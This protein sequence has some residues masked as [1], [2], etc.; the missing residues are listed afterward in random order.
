MDS[1]FPSM[2]SPFSA[3]SP[4]ADALRTLILFV[5][6]LV[7]VIALLVMSLVA[8]A[9]IRYRDRGTAVEPAQTGGNRKVEIAYT[10]IPLAIM[11]GLFALTV[12]TMHRAEPKETTAPPDLVI[13]AHQWWWELRYPGTDVVS[14][15][16]IH[17]PVGRKMVVELRSAD[18]IH[19][20]WV[21]QLAPKM[22]AVPGKPNRLIMEADRP[23]VYLGDCAEYCGVGHAWMRLRVVAQTP[24]DFA[25]W[26]HGQSAAPMAMT[27]SARSGESIF[28]KDTCVE[29]HSIQGIETSGNVGPNLTHF[30]TRA[31]LG[32][33][34]ADNT[35]EELALWLDNPQALKPG[36]YMPRMRLQ[37]AELKDLASYL[38][39]LR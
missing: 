21:P 27:G 18:V 32:A 4:E 35:P 10:L 31:T 17:L 33:G 20:V 25:A 9:V 16:E 36:C 3:H 14:A 7:S 37:P 30:A 1:S 13:V 38:E 28:Q 24:Q 6:T 15:N 2:G 23:G 34:V 8:Y 19:E 12:W 26:E 29:C 22:D 11:F 5:V 39:A